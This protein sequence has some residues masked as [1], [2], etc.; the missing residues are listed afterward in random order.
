M[1]TKHFTKLAAGAVS[2]VLVASTLAAC[3]SSGGSS[4]SGN[5]SGAGSSGGSVVTQT[6]Q[7]A[8][9]SGVYS[10]QEINAWIPANMYPSDITDDSAGD[11]S[12]GELVFANAKFSWPSMSCT[13]VVQDASGPGFG[14]VAYEINAGQNS[15]KGTYY[16]YGFYEFKTADQAAA[17]VRQAAAKFQSCGSFTATLSNGGTLP[18][19]F[20]LGASSVVAGITSADVAVDL[21]ENLTD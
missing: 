5:G 9:L 14:E 21:R 17:F 10:A 20:S 3:S 4:N 2:A 15:G 18:V 1:S 16:A 19:T 13:D 11:F 7:G 12:T 6:G 8:R